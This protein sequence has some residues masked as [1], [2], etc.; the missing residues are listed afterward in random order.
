MGDALRWQIA[1]HEVGHALVGAATGIAQPKLLALQCDGG[2]THADRRVIHQRRAEL[3]AALALDMA[4]RAAER[5]VF[6]EASAG[7]GGASDSDLARATTMA[8][9]IEA[10]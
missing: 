3:E 9:A 2:I 1:V 5:I 4:G 6:G 10:A 8:V 7:A